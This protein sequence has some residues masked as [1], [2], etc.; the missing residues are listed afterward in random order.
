MMRYI[1]SIAILLAVVLWLVLS[2]APA[3]L[4]SLPVITYGAVFAADTLVWLAAASLLLIVGL[5]GWVLIATGRALRRPASLELAATWEQFGLRFST[6]M[7]LTA[8]PLLIVIGLA[9]FVYL[10]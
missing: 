2:Y 8:L 4:G 9:A 3:L 6:E 1:I 5:Q 7:V 10:G